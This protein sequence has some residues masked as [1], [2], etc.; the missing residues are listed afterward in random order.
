MYEEDG[1]GLTAKKKKKTDLIINK[2]LIYIFLFF[3]G[4]N[5]V[6]CQWPNISILHEP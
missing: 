1:V 2:I 5:L 4:I 3:L 6:V